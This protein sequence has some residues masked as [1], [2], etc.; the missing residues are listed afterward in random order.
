MVLFL[1]DGISKPRS[2]ISLVFYGGKC[3]SFPFLLGRARKYVCI[4][5]FKKLCMLIFILVYTYIYWKPLVHSSTVS[6][7]NCKGF[8]LVSSFSLLIMLFSESEESGSCYWQFNSFPSGS[9]LLIWL[10]LLTHTDILLPLHSFWH[11]KPSLP[12][13]GWP[14]LLLDPLLS[15][16]PAGLKQEHFPLGLAL[17]HCGLPSIVDNLPSLLRCSSS[18]AISSCSHGL[19][20]QHIPLVNKHII[21]NYIWNSWFIM[22][23]LVSKIYAMENIRNL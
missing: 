6:T 11:S 16:M 22:L 20:C 7:N 15:P 13:Q 18:Q 2:E 10:S 4:Y 21:L 12:V 14:L 5:A 9:R 8:I 19:P 23:S 1:G 3:T 17:P